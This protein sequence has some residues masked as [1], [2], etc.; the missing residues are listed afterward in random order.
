MKFPDNEPLLTI[1]IANYN[2]GRFIESAICS[3]LQQCEAPI[4]NKE[5][6]IRLPIKGTEGMSVELVVCDAA[7]KD[8][9]VEIIR[10]YSDSLTWWCSENDGG[11]SAAFNKGFS[12]GTGRYLTWLN[13]DE[14]YLPGT[15]LAFNSKV[16]R[17]PQAKWI[18]GNL[19][20]FEEGSRTITRVSWGPHFQPVFLRR[21]RA[22]LDV[23]GPSSFV[24]RD[25]YDEIGPINER[26]HYSMDLEYW[27]RI[28][29]A[30][31]PQTRLNYVCWAFG[32]H[33]DSISLGAMTPE[34]V[35][36]GRAENQERKTRLGYSYKNSF[37]NI[38]YVIWI[39]CRLLDGSLLIR[40]W[41]RWRYI[42]KKFVG[43]RE[44]INGNVI[45]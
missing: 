33:P 27:A 36:A 43:C 24:R 45:I 17:N 8:N 40:M 5:G 44:A 31:V 25:L 10:K 14:E 3:V 1:V 38:W 32:I 19:L 15:L 28:T 2:Y 13:A 6:R 42:G 12:H 7:S 16:R 29:L 30:G 34:K 21:N 11:Q 37:S 18:T 4:K 41:K 22:C 26:F 23:F 9:S 35:K 39:V 20:E